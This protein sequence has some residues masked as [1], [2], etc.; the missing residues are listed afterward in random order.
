MWG[1]RRAVALTLTS[2]SDSRVATSRIAAHIQQT[3]LLRLQRRY[4]LSLGKIHICFRPR[5]VSRSSGLR[6]ARDLRFIGPRSIRVSTSG[7]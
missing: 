1:V 5:S 6:G 7:S 3:L 4:N 2:V